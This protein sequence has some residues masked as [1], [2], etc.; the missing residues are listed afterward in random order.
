MTR[1]ASACVVAH[2]RDRGL[3]GR[4][5]DGS[6]IRPSRIAS[7]RGARAASSAS[8]VATMTVAPC[9]RGEPGEQLDHV[10]ARL[11]VEVPG[12]LV[13]E[14]HARFDDER[15]GDRDSLLLA[16]GELARQVRGAVGEPDLAEQRERPGAQLA[17]PTPV[18]ASAASTFCR[19]SASGSG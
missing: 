4:G 17:S 3:G 10:G 5:G 18:G 7:R 12:R 11:R 8:W 13:G 9:S 14:D 1:M 16:A 19:R 2:R 6:T 15:P